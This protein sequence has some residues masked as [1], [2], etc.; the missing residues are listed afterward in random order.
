MSQ[1][2]PAGLPHSSEG[3]VVPFLKNFSDRVH[4]I[5]QWHFSSTSGRLSPLLSCSF[6]V[7]AETGKGFPFNEHAI[8][9]VCHMESR[10]PCYLCFF[11]SACW[12][13]VFGSSEDP[14]AGAVTLHRSDGVTPRCSAPSP[15][16]TELLAPEM[17]LQCKFGTCFVG[18]SVHGCKQPLLFW[19]TTQMLQRVRWLPQKRL[20]KSGLQVQTGLGSSLFPASEK[21]VDTQRTEVL[22]GLLQNFI[23]GFSG[24]N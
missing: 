19:E 16:G 8:I 3:F 9:P 23:D 11:L 2:Q 15:W 17:W 5:F 4:N 13:E 12:E 22:W 10:I 18:S 14:S 6:H 21:T 7:L 24:S 20:L 1:E